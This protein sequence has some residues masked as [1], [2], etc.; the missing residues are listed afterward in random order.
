MYRLLDI[1]LTPRCELTGSRNTPLSDA[2][3]ANVYIT[4]YS[5]NA[6]NDLQN[7]ATD[8]FAGKQ[9]LNNKTIIDYMSGGVLISAN[10][11]QAS[12]VEQFYKKQMV[13]RIVQNLWQWVPVLL[14]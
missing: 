3:S 9:D 7:W 10:L 8:T 6:R 1:R 11:P 13:S 2:S 4:R 5:E 12:D 14:R